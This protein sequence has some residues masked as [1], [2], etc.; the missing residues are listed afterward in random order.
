MGAT[1][2]IIPLHTRIFS[3]VNI[4]SQLVTVCSV[5]HTF[6]RRSYAAPCRVPSGSSPTRKLIEEGLLSGGETGFLSVI[7]P[8]SPW[9]LGNL[10][11]SRLAGI[12]ETFRESFPPSLRVVSDISELRCAY[13]VAYYLDSILHRYKYMP[14]FRFKLP[15]FIFA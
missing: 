9:R 3:R 11:Q 6:H 1:G 13:Y 5:L 10:P 4:A 8:V 15:I 14:S 2:V 7:C 12:S